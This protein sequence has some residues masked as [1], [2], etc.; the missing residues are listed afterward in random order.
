MRTD[1]VIGSRQSRRPPPSL[2]AAAWAGCLSLLL[3][4]L[5][6]VYGGAWRLGAV[7]I[8]LN[9]LLLVGLSGLTQVMAPTP[10][11]ATAALLW[12]ALIP[13]FHLGTA[14]H[15]IRLRWRT[16]ATSRW[17]GFQ[18]TLAA[19]IVAIAVSAAAN[20]AVPFGWRSLYT[21]SAS[22]VPTLQAGDLFLVDTRP[23]AGLPGRGAVIA[24]TLPTQPG[25]VYVKRL[26]GLPGDRVAV[27]DGRLI[28]NGET[29][30]RRAD[31][32]VS[33]DG[34]A[35]PRFVETLPFGPSYPIVASGQVA[36]LNTLAPV[37][38][39][40]GH[41]FVLGDNRDNSLDSRSFGSVAADAVIGPAMTVIWSS[42]PAPLPRTI[43]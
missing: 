38:V 15:A 6:Q 11:A 18:A 5:G 10:A 43:P 22:M 3:P 41:V 19:G 29:A 8:T 17:G 31:G 23:T 14:V 37:T 2:G 16:P 34:Q 27:R 39:P 30:A 20:L 9:T 1:D 12:L 33:L 4:G 36:A 13:L 21:A 40:P 42:A 7:L 32:T 26:I 25:S 24:F 28:L 35:V